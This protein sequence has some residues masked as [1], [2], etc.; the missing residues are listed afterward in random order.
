M[1]KFKKKSIIR[2]FYCHSNRPGVY[3]NER[4]NNTM[5]YSCNMHGCLYG[6]ETSPKIFKILKK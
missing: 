4:E 5:P 2:I 3:L 6:I 1:K